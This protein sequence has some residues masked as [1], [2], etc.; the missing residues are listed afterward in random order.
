M[1]VIEL[2]A[3]AW[4]TSLASTSEVISAC[5]AGAETALVT[6]SAAEHA[7]HDPRRRAPVPGERR[8]AAAEDDRG[9]LRA[10]D[11][12]APVEPVGPRARPRREQQHRRELAER[13]HAEQ[14]CR[15]GQPEDEDRPG[16]VLE[17]GP[18]RRG[19]VADEVRPE[20]PRAD[21]APGG[22]GPTCSAATRD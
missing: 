13:E 22:P 9:E 16:E 17:P 5:C 11:Q 20:V 21:D 18:A 8:E 10:Q 14:E 15:M 3:T 12:L 1:N 6:P 7:D 4:A 19:G 2:S